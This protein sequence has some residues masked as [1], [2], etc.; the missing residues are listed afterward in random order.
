MSHI[1][2]MGTNGPEESAYVI[3][4]NLMDGQE[5]ILSET[6]CYNFHTG[7]WALWALGGKAVVFMIRR[8]GRDFPCVV[9]ID[10][11]NQLHVQDAL[12]DHS[13]RSLSSD[14]INLYTCRNQSNFE[15][16]S[17]ICKTNLIN[18]KTETVA[19]SS[20]VLA[21]LPESLK[22]AESLCILNHPVPNDKES[23]IYFKLLYKASGQN[24]KFNSFWVKDT[25]EDK[26]YLHG[27]RISGHPAWMPD[28][29]NILNIKH[30]QDGSDNRWIVKVDC[31]TGADSR[32]MDF[33]IEGPGHLA[34]QPGGDLI[35]SDAFT[36]NGLASPIYLIDGKNRMGREI[37][38]LNHLFDGRAS[39]GSNNPIDVGIL[40]GQ[41]HPAFSPDGTK[42]AVNWNNAGNQMRLVILS[43]L[44]SLRS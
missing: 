44:P 17:I 38:R 15:Q 29:R 4:Q 5:T 14:G 23:R 18:S 39:A 35:V 40:R 20:E 26:F 33:P 34:V 10:K 24:Q 32:Y 13:I 42:L 30:P 16:E 3:I 25:I 12:P 36:A 28:G 22:E 11:P 41:P 7:A 37:I 27:N 19:T 21:L 6:T 8:Q 31:D 9:K 2:Y 1:L 43:N